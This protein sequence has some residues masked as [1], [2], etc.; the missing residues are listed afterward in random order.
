MDPKRNSHRLQNDDAGAGGGGDSG[1]AAAA[2]A[3]PAA[4]P[5]ADGQPSALSGAAAPEWSFDSIPE[6]LRV[7]DGEG[8]PDLQATI[9]KMDEQRAA[10]E[11]RMGSGDIRPKTPDEY[12]LPDSDTFKNLQLDADATAA[13]RK[14]AHDMG[15]SQ[16]QYEGIMNKWAT[17][18]PELVQAGQKESAESTISTL[19]GVWTDESAFKAN[20]HG[21]HRAAA[22][23]AQKAGLD[24]AEVDAAIGN[25]PAAIRLL[26][27]LAPELGED[28]TPASA[29]GGTG[30]GAT[31]FDQYMT[32]GDNW[33][34]Y[35]NK[36]HIRHAEVSREAARLTAKG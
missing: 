12:K 22:T 19:K 16:S 3:A 10:L 29:N 36:D 26:A 23:L 9:R 33:A 24:M 5:A 4:A 35:T 7:M 1:A 6:K 18:A 32:Q 21:A 17:L 8:K 30:A 25:N 28:S 20:M 11:K 34:A 15:L 31:T 14:E 27:A 13:F 2:A